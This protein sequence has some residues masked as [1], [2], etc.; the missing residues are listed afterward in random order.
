MLPE[1]G[2]SLRP[3]ITTGT[4]RTEYSVGTS[5]SM[6]AGSFEMRRFRKIHSF[7]PLGGRS[8]G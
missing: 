7:S 4:I 6:G 3:A 1:N 8:R 2:I 5:S